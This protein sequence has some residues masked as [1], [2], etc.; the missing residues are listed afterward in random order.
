MRNT[1]K[2]MS[3]DMRELNSKMKLFLSEM[4][5]GNMDLISENFRK[6]EPNQMMNALAKILPYIAEKKGREERM[7]KDEKRKMGDDVDVICTSDE[8]QVDEGLETR[9]ETAD[10]YTADKRGDHS[11]QD[12]IDEGREMSD[13]VE[14][15]SDAS[16]LEGREIKDG[17]DNMN[18]VGDRRDVRKLAGV[19][20]LKEMLARKRNRKDAFY[21]Q[22]YRRR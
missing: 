17:D 13:E 16:K 8:K 18:F 12:I 15:I 9:D 7:T 20:Q 2:M 1:K 3:D 6:L 21:K 19:D 4:I 5:N 22:F 11:R 10:H 14:G